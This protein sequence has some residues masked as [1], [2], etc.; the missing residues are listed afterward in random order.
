MKNTGNIFANNYG[1]MKFAPL[2]LMLTGIV[3]FI[4]SFFAFAFAGLFLCLPLLFVS[5]NTPRS[6]IRNCQLILIAL[7]YTILST[8]GAIFYILLMAISVAVFSI[9]VLVFILNLVKQ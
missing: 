7:L 6:F 5:W 3:T 2:L 1:L 9:G 4:F 8:P